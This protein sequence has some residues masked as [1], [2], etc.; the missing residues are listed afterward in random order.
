MKAETFGKTKPM[1]LPPGIR[2]IKRQLNFNDPEW[3]L[4]KL[5]AAREGI[6]VPDLIVLRCLTEDERAR[7]HG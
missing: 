6:S 7:T 5:A 4:L 2:R 1:K 3:R